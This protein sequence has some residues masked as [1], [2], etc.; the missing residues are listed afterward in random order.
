MSGSAKASP[1]TESKDARFSQLDKMNTAQI[2]SL[3]NQVDREVPLAIE[4][5]GDQ[6]A[7]AIDAISKN[8]LLGGRLIY[9]GAG[10]S[11]RI[12]TLDAS[13]VFPTFGVK[14]RVLAVMAGGQ[15]AL[16]NPSEGAEDDFEMGRKAIKDL[17]L[18]EID[19][20]V[21]VA[22]SGTTPF[23][24]G[25]VLEANSVNATTVG[26][27]CNTGNELSET[28]DFPIEAVVGPELIAGS[29][30]LK[31]GTAQ[32]M[33]L[34]MIST[35]TMIKAGKTYG[36]LMVDVVPSNKKLRQRA[37]NIV[38]EITGATAAEAEAELTGHQW[39]VKSAVVG[40]K[41]GIDAQKA[42]ALLEQ[43]NGYLALALGE[44]N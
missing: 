7:N 35:I 39:N 44:I 19:S 32:K 17:N 30:R 41:L 40:I 4:A 26:I 23:V 20:L 3:M 22:S 12:A 8:Y 36:N 18:T 37:I 1:I 38:S 34:N 25:A 16:V 21:G 15:D 33:I 9:I 2:V 24:L 29:T 6:I 27:A 28:V 43:S 10:T 31:A 13:E 5:A 42:A 11:G 14:D